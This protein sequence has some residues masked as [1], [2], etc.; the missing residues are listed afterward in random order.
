M[1]NESEN[2]KSERGGAGVKFLAILVILFLIGHAA[3]NYIPT[4]YEAENF[5]QEMQTAVVQSVAMPAIGMTATDGVKVK[6]QKASI[7]NNIP[8]DALIE[9][10]PVNNVIQARVVY[11]KKINL[12]P[13]GIYSYNYHFDHTATPTGFL[14]K[15]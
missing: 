5:K 1:F 9:I 2:R 12:L 4:A 11:T 6:L 7:N 13:F 15:E 8:S 14:F 3:F 10:K